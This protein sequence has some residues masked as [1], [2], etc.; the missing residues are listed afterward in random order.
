M[1]LQ[2]CLALNYNFSNKTKKT[3]RGPA[4]SH[5]KKVSPDRVPETNIF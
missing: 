1:V 5:L 2:P 3:A 4:G